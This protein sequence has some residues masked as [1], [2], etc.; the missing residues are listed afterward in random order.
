MA[1]FCTQ[2]GSALEEGAEFCGQCGARQE[3][4]ASAPVSPL[5]TLPRKSGSPFLKI[6]AAIL[7]F[8]ALVTV[9]GIG[10]CFYIGYRVKKKADQVQEA[11]K[12]NDLGKMVETL[13]GKRA[14][15]SGASSAGSKSS[16]PLNFPPWRPSSGSRAAQPSSGSPSSGIVPLCKGLTVVGAVTMFDSD[17]EAVTQVQKVTDI[18][19]L[20]SVDADNAPNPLASLGAP[21]DQRG[22]A[23]AKGS[24]HAIR[25]VRREDLQNARTMMEWFSPSH[26]EEF[27][28]ST[29]ISISTA[30]LNDLKT[31]GES[32]FSF[33]AGGLKG[34]LGA[35]AQ[36]LGQLGLGG[37]EAKG[38][39]EL[40]SFAKVECTL[41]REGDQ[42]Y[43]VRV[44]VND[45][46]AELPAVHA[47][48]T[49][50]D[51]TT[52]FYFLDDP[53]NALG[54]ATNFPGSNGKG[55]VVKIKYPLEAAQLAGGPAPGGSGGGGAGGGS[56][57]SAASAA[58]VRR[59]EQKLASERCVKI[60]GIYFDF[61]S[62]TM[63]PQSEP[64]LEEIA[65]VVRNNS[66]WKLSVE[67]HTDNIGGDQYN[68]DLSKRRA[69][70]VRSALV[71]RYHITAK[72][73]SPMGFGA[74][75]PV[76]PN[77]TLSGRALNRR[78]ELCRE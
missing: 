34:F 21:Q 65:Q 42:D 51:G 43:A 49:S 7:G 46:P 29:A 45:E 76:A 1:V 18:A 39:G 19:V 57:G 33:M 61:D 38:G 5:P 12:S 48:C 53:S 3:T 15:G 62:D 17:Y 10:S 67:G 68:R 11:Y 72:R 22:R 2:C 36:G 37:P 56:G 66:N 44:I 55:Q 6:V 14:A 27:P 70:A 25:S 35:M 47:T 60:Y 32:Q 58:N 69:T 52:D 30:V 74:A 50:E 59:M 16:S 26:P 24:V 20:L 41:K 75:R 77:D 54:L 78:V 8:F 13:G 31:K 71:E 64:G 9:I 40:S 73:L 23:P 4:L 63:K 28:G